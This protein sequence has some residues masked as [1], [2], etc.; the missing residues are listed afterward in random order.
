VN[1]SPP[2][3]SNQAGRLLVFGVAIG[4]L[5]SGIRAASDGAATRD[6]ESRVVATVV[7]G[8]RLRLLIGSGPTGLRE[9]TRSTEPT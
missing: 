6:C 2:A 4:V 5:G 8:E 3:P 7:V 1:P 9:L